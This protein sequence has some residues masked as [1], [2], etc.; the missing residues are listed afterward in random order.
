MSDPKGGRVC[1]GGGAQT[2]MVWVDTIYYENFFSTETSIEYIGNGNNDTF[3]RGRDTNSL[4]VPY[5]WF[6]GVHPKY[7]EGDLEARIFGVVRDHGPSV[8]DTYVFEMQERWRSHD[9]ACDVAFSNAAQSLSK[10]NAISANIPL[11]RSDW[12]TLNPD[13]TYAVDKVLNCRAQLTGDVSDSLLITT[14]QLR[15]LIDLGAL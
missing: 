4:D 14:I 5:Q 9:E 8:P 15:Y 2:Q 10:T 3:I 6:F 12:V 1:W 7:A 11:W 13:S